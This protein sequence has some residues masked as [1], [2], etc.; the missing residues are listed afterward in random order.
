MCDLC[1]SSEFLYS[2]NVLDFNSPLTKWQVLT[3]AWCLYEFGVRRRA[4]KKS[5]LIRC[6]LGVKNP[7]IL[8]KSCFV[9]C[10]LRSLC[11]LCPTSDLGRIARTSASLPSC[12]AQMASTLRVCRRPRRRTRLSSVARFC[13]CS[14]RR[15]ISTATCWSTSLTPSRQVEE[16]RIT[17]FGVAPDACRSLHS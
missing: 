1:K 16:S 5:L 17:L 2:V 9:N 3:R 11:G 6:E 4:G 8:L 13:W 10:I 7:V 15:P 12:V 14:S